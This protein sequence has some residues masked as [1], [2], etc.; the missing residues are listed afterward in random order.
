MSSRE[1]TVWLDERWY[2][3]LSRQLKDETLE[4]HLEN[5]LDEMCNALPE[6]EY[7]RISSEIYEEEM[8]NRQAAEAA[9]KF[10]IFRVTEQGREVLCQVDRGL[11]F[12]DAARL[13]RTYLRQERGASA[14]TQMLYRAEP[15]TQDRY[16]ELVQLRMDNTGKV[17]G[18]FELDF[19]KQQMSALNIMDGWQTFR[20]ADVSTAVYYADRRR[21]VSE[22]QRWSKFLDQLDGKALT[23]EPP[24]LAEEFLSGSR[25]LRP[26]DISFADEIMQNDHQLEFYMEVVFDPDAVFGTNVCTAENDDWLNVYANYDMERGQVCDTLEVYLVRSDGSEQDYK[27]RLSPEE[28]DALLPKMADYCQRQFGISLAD[29]CRQYHIE[30]PA[31][32][33]L[34]A[35]VERSRTTMHRIVDEKFNTFVR[36]VTLGEDQSATSSLPLGVNLASFKG[37]K[38]ASLF[39]PGQGEIPVSKWKNAVAAILQDCN[40]DPQRHD[41]LMELRNKIN[42]NFRTILSD[43][44][45]GMSVPLKIDEGLYFEGKFDTE[46]LLRVLTTKVLDKVGYNYHGILVQLRE[47]KQEQSMDTPVND[48]PSFGMKMK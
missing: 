28:Q 15:I 21:S 23:Y 13:L 11:E 10:A 32:G 41:R 30:N 25:R 6:R 17:A 26:E 42:G 45:D 18:A 16:D 19:D 12:L 48:A 40:A 43:K 8:A 33:Q 44:P 27:Y 39:L 38:P 35:E 2:N 37:T 47:P 14:F 31:P 9:K 22:D 36:R 24:A 29:C 7:E 3:A 20:M 34:L 5:V 1:V 46:S 4:E